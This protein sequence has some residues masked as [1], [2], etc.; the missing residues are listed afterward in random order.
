MAVA[1]A[2]EIDTAGVRV[3]VVDPVA[4]LTTLVAVIVT[5]CVELIGVG[6]V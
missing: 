5:L 1:G 3:I 6:A 4:P 2:S